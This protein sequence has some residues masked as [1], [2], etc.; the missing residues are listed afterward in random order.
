MYHSILNVTRQPNDKLQ[1]PI[2]K[3]NNEN[4]QLFSIVQ[5]Y[6]FFI[7]SF[8]IFYQKYHLLVL[9]IDFNLTDRYRIK[10]IKNHLKGDNG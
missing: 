8:K 9:K 2:Q 6:S 10:M 3:I 1:Q 7:K 4:C 5:T